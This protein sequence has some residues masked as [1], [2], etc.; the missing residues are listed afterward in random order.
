VAA[1]ANAGTTSKLSLPVNARNVR[2]VVAAW[3]TDLATFA[4]AMRGGGAGGAGAAGE[5]ETRASAASKYFCSTKSG[6]K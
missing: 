2:Q 4:S 6:D 5:K 1:V 3:K